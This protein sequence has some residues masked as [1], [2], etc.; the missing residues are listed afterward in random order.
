MERTNPHHCRCTTAGAHVH[1][2]MFCHCI[3][4][5]SSRTKLKREHEPRVSSNIEIALV[6]AA[7]MTAGCRALCFTK[8]ESTAC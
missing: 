5:R 1:P 3:S 2:R 7:L 4:D 8:G 6:L